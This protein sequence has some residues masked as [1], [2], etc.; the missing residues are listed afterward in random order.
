MSADRVDKAWQKQGLGK[1][2]V[3]AILG[4]L[5]HYGVRVSE[6]ELKT[7]SA[8][9]FPLAL[10]EGWM[11]SWKGTGQFARFPV[12]AADEL[13]ARLNPDR[14]SPTRY[15]QA[16]AALLTELS[17]LLQGAQD[18]KVGPGFKALDEVKA[19]VPMTEGKPSIAFVSE[20]AARLGDEGMKFFQRVAVDLAQQ[21]HLDDAEEVAN[22]EAFLFPQ[23][24]G[25]SQAMVKAAKGGADKEQAVGELVAIGKDTSRESI[26][27]ITALDALIHANAYEPAL[28]LARELFDTAEKDNDFHVALDAGERL[29][30]LLDKTGK[31]EDARALNE[32][33][34]KV[35]EAHG[36][37]HQH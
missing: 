35:A 1:Y 26:S 34:G 28:G 14:L 37:A 11:K 16:L 19:Q 20:V 6:E 15:A 29:V 30:W 33:L 31:R 13:W 9:K 17:R 21:G 12:H 27:R 2:S 25:I 22:L 18:A 23:L 24:S 8:E 32:R 5:G 7:Q 10:A 4:T 3:G 36:H